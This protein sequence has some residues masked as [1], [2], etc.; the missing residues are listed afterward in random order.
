MPETEK[1]KSRLHA[2]RFFRLALRYAVC[3]SKPTVLIVMGRIASGKSTLAHALGR[4]LDCEVIS[5]DRVRKELAG[6]PLYK[7][8]EESARRLYSEA[9]TKETYKMLFQCA[10]SQLDV[11]GSV[12]LDA[13]FGRSQHRDEL[14]RL[15]DSKGA[16]YRFI[17]A[18]AP[19][20][21]LKRRL[22]QR[23]GATHEISDAR[24]ENFET[25]TQSYEAPSEVQT[26]HCFQ[27]ATGRPAT[28][29]IEETLKGLVLAGLESRSRRSVMTC[30]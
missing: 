22:E 14:S 9:M 11:D 28:M 24:L 30:D 25:L 8:D 13:T 10:A 7:R 23:E 4:E 5:S 6:V 16:T 18:R 20:E 17:E 1:K 26:D 12:I 2:R 27:V 21:A 19:D 3:G 29:T 15:L